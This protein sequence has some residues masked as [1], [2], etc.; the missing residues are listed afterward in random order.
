MN[1]V[2]FL[3]HKPT[4]YFLLLHVLFLQLPTMDQLFRRPDKTPTYN[5]YVSL[6]LLSVCMKRTNHKPSV[7]VGNFLL[8]WLRDE[9]VDSHILRWWRSW[10]RIFC[11]KS[12]AN[13]TDTRQK[14]YEW[15]LAT[16]LVHVAQLMWPQTYR[17]HIPC[18]YYWS[19]CDP[20]TY[21][22]ARQ[23]PLKFQI[24]NF[25]HTKI[26]PIYGMC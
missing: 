9:V 4:K 7:V 14:I 24:R 11:N 18:R 21:Q 13:G 10:W 20:I 6:T 25:V 8:V 26:S 2:R 19:S 23:L 1:K 22:V 17:G 16:Q 3:H 12:R 5:L 15:S